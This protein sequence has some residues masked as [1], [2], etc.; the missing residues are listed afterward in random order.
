MKR[1]TIKLILFFTAFALIG[2][3]ATQVFWMTNAIS[4]SEDQFDHRVTVALKDVM[5]DLVEQGPIQDEG[6]GC[7]KHCSNAAAFSESF[8]ETNILDSLLKVHFN[9]H[10]LD[11]IFE[12]A[13]VECGKSSPLYA[14]TGVIRDKLPHS[15][16]TTGLSCIVK[17]S[18]YNLEVYFPEKTKFVIIQTL[19]WLIVSFIFILIVLLS[20]LFI[21]RTIIRQKR[22]SEM[23]NDFINN[24]THEFKTPIST[25]SMASEILLKSDPA[26]SPE[27]FQK[28][29][30]VIY[31]ENQ[32]LKGQVEKVLEIAAME[33]DT[34]KIKTEPVNI[35]V[36]IKET[37]HN[38]C[39]EVCPGNIDLKYNLMEEDIF[40]NVD[41]IHITNVIVNLVDNAQ[42][43]SSEEIH[44][45]VSTRRAEE[46]LVIGIEDK[47]IG[48]SQETVRKI[49]DK[50]YRQHTG[51]VHD[52]KGFGL[53]LFYVRSIIEKHKGFVKVQSTL[54]KG[55][56]FEV[57]LPINE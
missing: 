32:R 5:N 13:I 49:F 57:F 25:I 43:Y 6:G 20:F 29:S 50:F 37:V 47:G 48:M 2:L 46:Y 23:K 18:C 30:K 15:C 41:K 12:Y 51:D 28:Y 52:V 42:K 3:I 27:R 10:H 8:I 44:I 22:L 35:N 21:V 53:G 56:L 7:S 11:T 39:L 34:Y 19:T 31:D 33:K 40:L 26:A 45:S 24:M 38:L 16:H 1:K 36:L 4:L 14:K 55:S 54:G 9:Y 17:S